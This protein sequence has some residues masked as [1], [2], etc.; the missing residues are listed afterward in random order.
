MSSHV[1]Q[2]WKYALAK[3]VLG[4]V[5]VRLTSCS[6]PIKYID[7]IEL[8]RKVREF[9]DTHVST[10]PLAMPDPQAPDVSLEQEEESFTI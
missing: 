10:P 3:E 1:D 7:I 4:P 9:D 5:T 2:R 8:D 6:I